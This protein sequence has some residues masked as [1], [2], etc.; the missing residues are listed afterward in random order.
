MQTWCLI[1]ILNLSNACF[2]IEEI[3]KFFSLPP[4]L[5]EPHVLVGIIYRLWPEVRL[6]FTSINCGHSHYSFRPRITLLLLN[7]Y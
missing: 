3:S 7:K 4:I 5:K 2:Q 6:T 1:S